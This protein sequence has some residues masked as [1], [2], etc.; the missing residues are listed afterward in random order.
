MSISPISSVTTTPV[1]AKPASD[2]DSAAVE[3]AES[4]ATK[5]AELANGGSAPKAAPA[6]AGKSSSSSND[7]ARIRMLASQHM[8]ASQIATQLGKSVSAVMQE[9]AAAGIN[10]SAGSTSGS[11][12]SG[13]QEAAAAGINLSAGSTSGSSGSADAVTKSAYAAI[14]KGTNIDATA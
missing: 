2:G 14:G 11:S 8:S 5:S 10:L 12:T 1:P 9:A 6:S 7:L 4:N 13:M 3:A